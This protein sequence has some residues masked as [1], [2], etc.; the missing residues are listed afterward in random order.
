MLA[1][2]YSMLAICLYGRG[3]VGDNI[4]DLTCIKIVLL[5]KKM[6]KI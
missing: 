1:V 6:L 2:F 4:S 5:S 3:A